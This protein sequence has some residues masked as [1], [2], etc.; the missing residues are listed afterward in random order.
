[1]H[2]VGSRINLSELLRIPVLGA[3]DG[4]HQS[5]EVEQHGEH[6]DGDDVGGDRRDGQNVGFDGYAVG[7]DTEGPWNRLQVGFELVLGID[8][9]LYFELAAALRLH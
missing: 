2:L 8:K 1:M 9:A 7:D 4:N 6:E 5:L 3:Y